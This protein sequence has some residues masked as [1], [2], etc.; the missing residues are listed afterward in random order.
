MRALDEEYT[1]KEGCI[2]GLLELTAAFPPTVAKGAWG[3]EF[4]GGVEGAVGFAQLLLQLLG[5]AATSSKAY[6]ALLR[7]LGAVFAGQA[8]REAAIPHGLKRESGW[9][10]LVSAGTAGLAGDLLLHALRLLN[11]YWHVLGETTP[12]SSSGTGQPPVPSP[13]K[14]TLA[15]ATSGSA[16]APSLPTSASKAGHRIGEA[17]AVPHLLRLHGA[18]KGAHANY[19]ASLDPGV[20]ERFTDVLQAALGLFAQTAEVASLGDVSGLAEEALLY[21]KATMAVLPAD[22]VTGVTSLLRALFGTNLSLVAPSAGTPTG[23]ASFTP[24]VRPAAAR[25]VGAFGERLLEASVRTE[26]K[27]AGLNRHLGW[28]GARGDRH[29]VGLLK[30]AQS[31]ATLSTF[32]RFFEPVVVQVRPTS[33][34]NGRW[35]DLGAL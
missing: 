9:P 25:Q 2:G 21:L 1:L 35:D 28:Q 4:G 20:A 26:A 30:N 5:P 32:I 8:A 7:L 17:A 22:S 23:V 27:L 34:R 14:R 24:P 12:T 15:K 19:K 29:V 6:A 3:L 11:L 31:K 10:L 16:S 18:L 33:H 13:I